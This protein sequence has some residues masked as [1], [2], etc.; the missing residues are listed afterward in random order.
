MRSFSSKAPPCLTPPSSPRLSRC[1]DIPAQQNKPINNNAKKAGCNPRMMIIFLTHYYSYKLYCSPR[2]PRTWATF[3]FSAS[4]SISVKAQYSTASPAASRG[5]CRRP[6]IDEL[7]FFVQ[8][9]RLLFFVSFVFVAWWW[10]VCVCFPPPHLLL[11]SWFCLRLFAF[12]CLRAGLQ[13]LALR[14]YR[15]LSCLRLQQ[16]QQ[17]RNQ[18]CT[19][20]NRRTLRLYEYIYIILDRTLRLFEK[21]Y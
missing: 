14:R 12:I 1:L 5:A 4:S 18:K 10:C 2:F 21:I 9:R 3:L 20:M 15:F 7:F 11:L 19:A 16:Q 13:G 6:P 8:C 17:G